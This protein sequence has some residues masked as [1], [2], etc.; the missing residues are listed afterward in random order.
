MDPV[1]IILED[2]EDFREL[3]SLALR[4]EGFQVEDFATEEAAM[5]FVEGN[6]ARVSGIVADV[7][8]RSG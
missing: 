4:H 7:R 6:A 2:D 1:V 3:V 8:A 5:A